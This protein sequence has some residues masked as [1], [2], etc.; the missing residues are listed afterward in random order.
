MEREKVAAS[1][2]SDLAGDGAKEVSHG[3]RDKGARGGRDGRR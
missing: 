2:D 3:I 1:G